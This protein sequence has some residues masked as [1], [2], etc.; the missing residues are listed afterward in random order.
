MKLR[1]G[2]FE[3]RMRDS[4]QRE[5]RADVTWGTKVDERQRRAIELENDEHA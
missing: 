4:L 3:G 2:W 1:P 5:V